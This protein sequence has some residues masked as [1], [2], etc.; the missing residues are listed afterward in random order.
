[1]ARKC[2]IQSGGS[3]SNFF[4][5][6]IFQDFFGNFEKNTDRNSKIEISAEKIEIS[7]ILAVAGPNS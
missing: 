4:S 5:K 3:M 2:E 7:V 1:M 6:I